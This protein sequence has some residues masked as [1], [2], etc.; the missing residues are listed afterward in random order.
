MTEDEK[1]IEEKIL[2]YLTKEICVLLNKNNYELK[3]IIWNDNESNIDSGFSKIAKKYCEL[4]YSKFNFPYKLRI[5]TPD[6][7]LTFKKNNFE[8]SK[9]IEL[10]STKSRDGILPGSTLMK[11][12]PNI[13]TIICKRDTKLNTFEIRYGRYYNGMQF[14][15]HE[16][17]Q[18]RSPRPNI[19]FN[20]FQKSDE[21]PNIIKTEAVSNFW[22]NYAE[23]AIERVL[24]PLSHS[25]QDD[26]VKAI[27]RKVIKNPDIFKNI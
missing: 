22:E 16:T 27:I 2:P 23:S 9:K 17:F 6:V 11:L 4:A 26:L 3:K 12:D 19:N 15:N 20:K 8:I 18:D 25:W 13:W 24:N 1:I 10:K 14:S 5:D 7:L 21:E